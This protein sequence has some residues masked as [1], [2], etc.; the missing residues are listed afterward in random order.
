MTIEHH[1]AEDDVEIHT[2]RLFWVPTFALGGWE[3]VFGAADLWLG[4]PRFVALGNL[5][6]GCLMV[7]MA[8]SVRTH[9]VDLTPQSA[10]LRGLRRRSVPWQD[11]QAVLRY[12]PHGDLFVRL[13]LED[14]KPVTLRAPA[15]LLGFGGANYERD[16][17]RIGQW[18]LA[19]RGPS[20]RPV[21][22]EAPHLPPQG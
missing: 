7:S 14:G 22:A 15:T 2:S 17:H 8:L 18:W 11:V 10:K 4:A 3:L 20:W 6:V 12:Q 1:A 13:I 19:H 5:V 21:R 9:G 16:F